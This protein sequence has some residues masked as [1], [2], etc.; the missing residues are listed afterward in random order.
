ML[1][2]FST[3]I[4]KIIY[5]INVVESLNSQ[6]RKFTENKLIFPT[7]ESLLKMLYL[8]NERVNSK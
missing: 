2:L 5:I 4:R 1:F 3:H 8:S 7:D 6:F